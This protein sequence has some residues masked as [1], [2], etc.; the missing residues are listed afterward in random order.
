LVAPC[1]VLDG[2]HH[3]ATKVLRARGP[4][5]LEAPPDSLEVAIEQGAEQSAGGFPD[6]PVRVLGQLLGGPQDHGGVLGIA[7]GEQ[8]ARDLSR[9]R[10]RCAGERLDPAAG[11]TRLFGKRHGQ[12]FA[13]LLPQGR[14]ASRPSMVQLPIEGGDHPTRIIAG[15]RG[16]HGGKRTLL[17]GADVTDAGGRTHVR[18][19]SMRC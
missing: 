3:R 2:Q 1:R 13:D 11:A 6:F 12:P 5:R 9:G 8:Q 4:E 10:R 7:A 19:I 17:H 14:R 16:Q 15:E 18:R